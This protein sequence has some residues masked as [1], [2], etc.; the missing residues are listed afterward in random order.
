VIPQELLEPEKFHNIPPR[1]PTWNIQKTVNDFV[2]DHIKKVA[3]HPG[4]ISDVAQRVYVLLIIN[5]DNI[6]IIL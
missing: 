5:Y 4:P 6:N 2:I 1:I 3:T